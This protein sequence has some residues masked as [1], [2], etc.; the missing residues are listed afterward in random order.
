VLSR[1]EARLWRWHPLAQ[2]VRL[3]SIAA[4]RGDGSCEE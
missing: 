4:V 1:V 3:E 2:P